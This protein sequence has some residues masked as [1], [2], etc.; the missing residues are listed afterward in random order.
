MKRQEQI[1][2]MH[3]KKQDFNKLRSG[4]QG[5]LE[6]THGKKEKIKGRKKK[7]RSFLKKK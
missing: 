4:R 1:N 3:I 6:Q 7:G 5:C 2:T